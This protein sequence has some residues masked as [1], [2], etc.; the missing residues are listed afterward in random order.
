MEKFINLESLSGG[1]VT[2]KVNIE[3]KK[4]LENLLDVNTDAGKKRKIVL[5]L[6][7]SGSPERDETSMDYEIKTTLVP[8]FGGKTRLL[9]GKDAEGNVKAAEIAKG[10]IPGQIETTVDETTGEVREQVIDFRK[11]K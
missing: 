11:V 2:E 8:T 9:M 7:F 10:V 5:T 6:T 1:A 3:L 4:V